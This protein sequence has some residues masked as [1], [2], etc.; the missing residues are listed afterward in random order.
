MSALVAEL[1]ENSFYGK[2]IEDLGRHRG[3]KFTRKEE[4]RVV[5][6][7]TGTLFL[8]INMSLFESVPEWIKGSP[9]HFKTQ[10][11][12]NDAVHMEPHS[13]AFVP[14]S[15]KTEEMCNEAVRREPYTLDYHSDH[16]KTQKMCDAAVREDPTVFFL[17]LIILKHKKCVSRPLKMNQKP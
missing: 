3:T 8:E 9:D 6:K 13:L 12:C 5:E 10:D 11:I 7:A 15:L 4:K 1:K 14:D 2:I 17:F 16:F